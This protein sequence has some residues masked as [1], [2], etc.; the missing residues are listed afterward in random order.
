M[1]SD[2]HIYIIAA[3]AGLLVGFAILSGA[4]CYGAGKWGQSTFGL[5]YTTGA[6]F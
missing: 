3:A 6:S 1:P 4:N 5:A 2:K